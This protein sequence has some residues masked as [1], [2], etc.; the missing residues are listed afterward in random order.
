[1]PAHASSSCEYRAAVLDDALCIGVLATQVFLDTYATDGVRPDLAREV[2]SGYSPEAFLVR[3]KDKATSFVLAERHGHLVGFA[4][5][6]T[7]RPC[8]VASIVSGVE[9]VRLYVQR[10]FQR[11]GIGT[12]LLRQAEALASKECPRTLWL[13]VWSGNYQA[14]AFYPYFQYQNV[15]VTDYII[16]GRTYENQVFVKA[17]QPSEP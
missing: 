5:V 1:M 8:P 13:T 9:L 15:G 17:L 4:E 10:A 7:K 6:T 11:R 12:G 14:L 3:L 16:E 2:L